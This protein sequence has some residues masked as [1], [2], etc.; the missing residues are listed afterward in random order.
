MINILGSLMENGDN[1]K[2]QMENVNR[3]MKTLKKE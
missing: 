3:E 2:K 1:K